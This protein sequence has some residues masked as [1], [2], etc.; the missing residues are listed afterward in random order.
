MFVCMEVVSELCGGGQVKDATLE[1]VICIDGVGE[2]GEERSWNKILNPPAYK[3][4]LN[5]LFLTVGFF[6]FKLHSWAPL[7]GQ[8]YL[9]R[10]NKLPFGSPTHKPGLQSN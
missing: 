5:D 10:G 4:V 3:S 8:L 9:V 1:L 7:E 6:P 2:G